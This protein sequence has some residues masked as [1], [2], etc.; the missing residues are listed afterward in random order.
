MADKFTIPNLTTDEQDTIRTT[1]VN[2]VSGQE[3]TKAATKMLLIDKEKSWKML[4]TEIRF[5][6]WS[7]GSYFPCFTMIMECISLLFCF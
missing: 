5:L 1:L 3:E 4:L 2:V 6:K 7:F